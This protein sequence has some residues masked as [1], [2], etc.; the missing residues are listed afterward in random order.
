MK[1]P[2]QC[3]GV[4]D[5]AAKKA[6]KEEKKASIAVAP[7]NGGDSGASLSRSNTMNSLSSSYASGGGVALGPQRMGSKMAKSA[8]PSAVSANTSSSSLN[9]TVAAAATTVA[10]TA[11]APRRN[12]VIAPPPE[13]YIAA[14]PP[15]PVGKDEIMGKMIYTY[16]ANGE[17]EIS[18]EGGQ[19]VVIVEPDDGSGWIQVQV[20]SQM[21]LVPASYV[22]ASPPPTTPTVG[23]PSSVYSSS[24]ASIA[25]STIGSITGGGTVK[26]KGPA[27]KPKRGAKRVKHVEALYDYEARTDAEWSMAEGDRFVLVREDNGDGWCDVEKAGAVK[28]VPANYVQVVD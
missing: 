25:N 1:V 19:E 11:P 8:A 5:K 17:G 16:A 12:R 20:G 14:P 26:K 27:V 18:V 21:G 28:S 15:E 24:N 23:R 22:D 10:A 4:L 13:R 7:A 6:L 3:P 2:A 9:T